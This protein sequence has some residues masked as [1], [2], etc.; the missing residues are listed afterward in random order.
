MYV[1]GLN[2]IYRTTRKKINGWFET[3]CCSETMDFFMAALRNVI[4]KP[5]EKCQKIIK[6]LNWSWINDEINKK[7]VMFFVMFWIMR[8]WFSY[9]G[10]ICKSKIRFVM[11]PLQNP[12]LCGSPCETYF[13]RYWLLLLGSLFNSDLKH[14]DTFEVRRNIFFFLIYL[15]GLRAAPQ[16]FFRIFIL[17]TI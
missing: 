12:P 2:F 7:N 16:G 3:R 4:C 6:V 15:L 9:E 11:Q 14:T 1:F 17:F 8:Y 10:K 13:D 5:Q